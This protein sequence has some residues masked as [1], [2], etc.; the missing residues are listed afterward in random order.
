MVSPISNN[1]AGHAYAS[2]R[3]TSHA[4][5]TPDAPPTDEA[6][7]LPGV[8]RNLMEGHY[9]G[10]ADVRLRL[11][12]ADHIAALQLEAD[13]GLAA[14]TRASTVGELQ[15]AVDAFVAENST[16]DEAVDGALG[17]AASAFNTDVGQANSSLEAA[18]ATL[19]ESLRRVLQPVG[20]AVENP[21][22]EVVVG[23]PEDGVSEADPATQ[24]ATAIAEPGVVGTQLEED[25]P[26]RDLMA[27]LR[28]IVDAAQADPTA[29]SLL[30]PL[31]ADKGSGKAYAKFVELYRAMSQAP[32]SQP[33]EGSVGLAA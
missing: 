19:E 21:G 22:T 20:A 12:H 4:R 1:G 16:G 10:V 11:V 30:P 17:A 13:E 32:P 18:L 25:D 3:P 28:A 9:K 7:K 33:L 2:A 8:I 29:Q 23:E 14:A 15:G 26:I 6:Q 31:A 5:E 24:G 27:Q